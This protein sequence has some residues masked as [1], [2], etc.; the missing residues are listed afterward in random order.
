MKVPFLATASD[1]WLSYSHLTLVIN[2]PTQIKNG[3]TWNLHL[4]GGYRSWNR[5]H[6]N[7]VS[8]LL[9]ITRQYTEARQP[10]FKSKLGS[11]R[12]PNQTAQI[13]KP[14]QGVKYPLKSSMLGGAEEEIL[15]DGREES[16][17]KLVRSREVEVAKLFETRAH[18]IMTGRTQQKFPGPP[19]PLLCFYF[20]VSFG[21]AA[22][23][24]VPTPLR[25]S[26]SLPIEIHSKFV[27][28]GRIRVRPI[29][30]WQKLQTRSWRRNRKCG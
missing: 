25:E 13:A 16:F 24:T 20:L 22:E 21:L 4:W 28:Q 1:T 3:P 7:P 6:K 9:K 10:D 30:R 18:V 12:G 2:L 8:R 11:K 14:L 17:Q 19:S 26:G 23:T 15:V 29:D 5:L 27:E